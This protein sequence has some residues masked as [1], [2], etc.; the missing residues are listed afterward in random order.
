MAQN[1]KRPKEPLSPRLQRWFQGT[2]ST[3]YMMILFA[4][5]AAAVSGDTIWSRFS[6]IMADVY[7]ELVG[8]STIVAVTAASVA[9]L[10]RMISRTERAVSE[11]TSWLKRIIVTWVVLNTLGFAVAYLQPLIQGGQYTP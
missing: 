1:R 11:A 5:P 9:L 7:G 4:Q 10:V 6:S 3:C 2:A 8:I